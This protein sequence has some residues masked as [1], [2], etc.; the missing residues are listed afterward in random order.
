MMLLILF[1]RFGSV[2]PNSELSFPEDHESC[3]SS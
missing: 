2:M 1:V 3:E